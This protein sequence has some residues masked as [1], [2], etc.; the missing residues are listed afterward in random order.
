MLKLY[1]W[2]N[3]LTFDTHG[4]MFALAENIEQARELCLEQNN[5][6]KAQ[7]DILTEPKTYSSPSG[8]TLEGAELRLR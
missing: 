6:A 4:L 7:R 2:K 3:V 1:V 8:F 5:S